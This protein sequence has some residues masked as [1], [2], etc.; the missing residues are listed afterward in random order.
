MIRRA[1][2]ITGNAAHGGRSTGQFVANS[3]NTAATANSSGIANTGTGHPN[4]DRSSKDY[5]PVPEGWW[6][7]R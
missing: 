7:S 1:A 6:R 5:I 3:L 2:D 4:K